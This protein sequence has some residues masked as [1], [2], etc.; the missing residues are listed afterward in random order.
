[1]KEGGGKEVVGGREGRKEGEERGLDNAHISIPFQEAAGHGGDVV[2]REGSVLFQ[3][4]VT[5]LLY[6]CR[7]C[8]GQEV[9]VAKA[10]G[11][12]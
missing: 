3:S 6:C 8:R 12:R 1:M 10:S 2:L 7:T 11:C 9:G 5:T 4:V